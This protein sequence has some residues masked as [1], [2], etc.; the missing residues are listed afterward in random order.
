MSA[1]DIRESVREEQLI[2]AKRCEEIND[3]TMALETERLAYTGRADTLQVLLE[4]YE[5][6]VA[7]LHLLRI[8]RY[9]R[10]LQGCST[11]I[12]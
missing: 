5:I 1:S 12:A 7:R 4:L 9:C 2:I 6:K 3:F 8:F 11:L 10:Y